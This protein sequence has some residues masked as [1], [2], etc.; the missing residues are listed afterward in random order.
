MKT[1]A[2]VLLLL[3]RSCMSNLEKD[4]RKTVIASAKDHG[5]HV[6]DI[7][8]ELKR[9][10]SVFPEMAGK[11]K[12]FIIE[13]PYDLGLHWNGNYCALELKKITDA[14][15]FVP[16]NI[17][18]MPHQLEGLLEAYNTG[19]YS[20]LLVQ[21]RFGITPA[22][23]AKYNIDSW[24]LDLTFYIPTAILDIDHKYTFKELQE[25]HIVIPKILEKDLLDLSP[26]WTMNGPRSLNQ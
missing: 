2:L 21:F 11:L 3:E 10:I 20:G 14:W 23:K 18:E 24:V 15:S 22:Q 8:D 6:V 7:V 4:L 26:I 9:A 5:Y 19:G 12:N 13:K 1:T 16:R 17:L 25:Q